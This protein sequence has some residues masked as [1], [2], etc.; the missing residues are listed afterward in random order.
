M[1]QSDSVFE[2]RMDRRQ[3][4]A[5]TCTGIIGSLAG[6]SGDSGNGSNSSSGETDASNGGS[7]SQGG[8]S[9]ESSS[10]GTDSSSGG[11]DNSTEDS[12]SSTGNEPGNYP[13]QETNGLE[14]ELDRVID[15]SDTFYGFK[16]DDYESLNIEEFPNITEGY[17]ESSLNE[18]A[19]TNNT[20][21]ALV[22]H[23]VDFR[24]QHRERV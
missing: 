17:D 2:S 24:A 16:V 10:D 15:Q 19:K 8:G 14:S 20:F 23:I 4:L 22:K 11:Q 13:T 21:N 18:L 9:T 12:G 1:K 7:T 3:A 5:V 6:C